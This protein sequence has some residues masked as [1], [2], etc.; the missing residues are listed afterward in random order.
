MT[1]GLHDL[2]SRCKTCAHGL[3]I[4]GALDVVGECFDAL[5]GGHM[6]RQEL[7][8]TKRAVK[9]LGENERNVVQVTAAKQL[10]H[11]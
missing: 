3:R 11:E 7:V 4:P 10:A 6:G 1:R 8:M 5:R 9:A 2:S